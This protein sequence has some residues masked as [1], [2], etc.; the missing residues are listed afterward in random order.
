[1]PFDVGAQI[2]SRRTP[3][4]K[5]VPR[6]LFPDPPLPQADRETETSTGITQLLRCG[7]LW[8]GVLWCGVVCCGVVCCG[9]VWCAV[10]WG[11]VVCCAVVWGAV[12]CCAVV[13]CAVVWRNATHARAQME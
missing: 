1:M 6:T 11:A 2:E 12:V 8:C 4:I 9:V 7:V 13:W 10:V 5:K 3:R